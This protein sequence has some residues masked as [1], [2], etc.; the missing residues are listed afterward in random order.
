MSKRWLWG[1]CVVFVL[2]LAAP[3]AAKGGGE[4]Q[5]VKAHLEL[6]EY[7]LRGERYEAALEHF[8]AVLALAPSLKPGKGKKGKKGAAAE[9]EEGLEGGAAAE[10]PEKRL[11]QVKFRA[12]MGAAASLWRL[13]KGAEAEE[14]AGAA[15]ALARAEGLTRAEQIAERF[16]D[17]PQEAVLRGAPTARE[18]ESFL[19]ERAEGP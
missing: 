12:M 7:D 18:L 1:A 17:D 2:A 8:E 16:L 6:G 14:R 4:R 3:A 13:G 19:K 11:A 15:L 9:V 5:E 10:S